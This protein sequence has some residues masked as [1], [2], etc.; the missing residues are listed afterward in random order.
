MPATGRGGAEGE[1]AA[2]R[3][4][5]KG[6]CGE[7]TLG[8]D[9]RNSETLSAGCLNGLPSLGAQRRGTRG[10]ETRVSS[11]YPVNIQYT[12][13]C[14][15]TQQ[16]LC[17]LKHRRDFHCTMTTLYRGGLSLPASTVKF[18]K[19]S[20]IINLDTERKINYRTLSF[21]ILFYN[22]Q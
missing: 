7:S 12:R 5:G 10:G 19:L 11:T 20:L 2:F 22:L 6:A 4:W 3:C 21:G 17:H 1:G 13:T 8:S 14:C 18:G 16:Q 9:P 15:R